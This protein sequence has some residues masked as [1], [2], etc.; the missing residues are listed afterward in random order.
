MTVS[1]HQSGVVHLLCMHNHHPTY[2]ICTWTLIFNSCA[3]FTVYSNCIINHITESHPSPGD[4]PRERGRAVDRTQLGTK[5]KWPSETQ[6]SAYAPGLSTSSYPWRIVVQP[7]ASSLCCS[8]PP[9]YHLSS[10]TSVSPVPVLHLYFRHQ[11]PSRHTILIQSF[12]MSNQLNALTFVHVFI[13]FCSGTMTFMCVI[14]IN[15]T[16]MSDQPWECINENLL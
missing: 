14:I 7:P 5:Q 12:H 6:S 4:K 1:L 8:R 15:E 13:Q 3:L 9:L 10:L 16:F 11:Q 2:T